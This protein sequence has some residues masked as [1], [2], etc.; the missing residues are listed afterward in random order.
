MSYAELCARSN[1]SFLEGAS[2]P[3]E[4]IERC[5]EAGVDHLAL[6][7]RDGVYGAVEAHKAA[8]RC[9]VHLVHGSLLTVAEQPGVVLL[10]E[11]L[12][13]WGSLCRLI[14]HARSLAPK[15]HARV[16]TQRVAEHAAGLRCLLRP[17]WDVEAARTLR[18]AFG[19]RLGVMWSRDLT[20][21]DRW[22]TSWA[23]ETSAALDVPMLA[24]NDAC[25]HEPSRRELADVLTCIRRRSTL[26]EAGRYLQGNSEHYLLREAQFRR[27]Y[28]AHPDAIEIARC[29]AAGCTFSLDSLRY[30][31]PSEV[32]PKGWT[33]MSWLRHEVSRGLVCRYPDGVPPRVSKT[34]EYELLI[35]EDLNFSSYFLTVYDLVVFAKDRGILCQGRGSAANSVVCF[36]LG[37]TCVDPAQSEMLFERFLSKERGEPPDIDVDFEHERREEVLQYVYRRYGRSRAAMVCEVITYRAR[38]AIRDVGTVFGL[39]VDAV[40]RLAKSVSRGSSLLSQESLG[41][42][43]EAGLDPA[44]HDILQTLSYSE[45]LRG[46]PRH[47]SIHTGGFVISQSPLVD[48]VPVE[49][50]SKAKRTVV[51]WTKD[52]IAGVQFVKVDVLSLGMLTCIRKALEAIEAM[53]G[54]RYTLATIPRED[55]A[56]YDMF[57][58]ADTVGV[59]QIESRAQMSMLPRLKPRCF[60]DLV[61]QISIVRPGPIQGGMV[62]PYLRRRRG[63]ERITYAHP[64]LKPILERTLGV[65]LF[66]EQVMAMAVAVGGFTP[67]QADRLRRSM[68]KWRKRGTIH[69]MRQALV[70]GMVD[71]GVSRRYAEAVFDQIVGF[72]EY[73]F[74]ES[75]AA[76]F[77]WLVYV[78][79]WLRCH[80]LPAF[81]IAL[82]NSQPMG[83]YSPRSI[84]EDARHRG[85]TI[86]PVCVQR[87]MWDC[88]LERMSDGDLAVRLGLRMVRGLGQE[89][90]ECVVR[91]RAGTR[92]RDLAEMASR[93]GLSRR[94]LQSLARARA[95]DVFG[96]TRREVA[97]VLQGLWSQY[98]LF[99]SLS[100]CEP[101]PNVPPEDRMTKVQEDYIATGWSLDAHPIALIRERLGIK[102]CETIAHVKRHASLRQASIM[103][104]ITA[105]QRPSTAN[106][107]VF[108]TLEDETGMMQLVVWPTVWER[109]RRL[110]GHATA[111]G[112]DGKVQREGQAVSV[113]AE[114]FWSLEDSR[115]DS[116]KNTSIPSVSRDFR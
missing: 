69:E 56:V 64:D 49:P 59:F 39:S 107:V 71:R 75:H 45:M 42:V 40:D 110:V 30:D 51:Q 18:E 47:L 14:T 80:H 52:D 33:P 6:V 24:S 96:L 115:R 53:G 8:Q 48:L 73:G 61:V 22:R 65:P 66:Q 68:G 87:S 97:W 5:A 21:A 44:A 37:I 35:I 17:G 99:G 102:G 29:W 58:R 32:V 7:D 46:V 38:S 10:V 95:F 92:F 63:E 20:S 62:H 114:R 13:G 82:I 54:P 19:E 89:A 79:G 103:G 94:D 41:R 67:G 109:F 111:I 23:L 34:A 112:I 36:A 76:S 116:L 16:I 2:H 1:F 105:R 31:Y 3:S 9:G 78:S 101:T 27:R 4:L 77:A 108:V 88:T 113:L 55:S 104:L 60:Y 12:E 85:V 91:A 93:S 50:A 81:V 43:A 74:P 72:G 15:G 98:P 83:F 106:G 90:G 57:C 70:S 86:R 25:F 100:R 84:L 11:D 28:A 26:G